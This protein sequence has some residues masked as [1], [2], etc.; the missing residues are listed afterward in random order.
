[1]H[2]FDLLDQ[3]AKDGD[4]DDIYD[5]PYPSPTDKVGERPDNATA[6]T[7]LTLKKELVSNDLSKL[8]GEGEETKG[9]EWTLQY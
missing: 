8:T 2:Y 7:K 1:M 5:A 3:R 6:A 9:E 4:T